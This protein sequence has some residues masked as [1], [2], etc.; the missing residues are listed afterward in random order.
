MGGGWFIRLRR[1]NFYRLG[2]LGD[3][4]AQ[5]LPSIDQIL[6]SA[7]EPKLFNLSFEI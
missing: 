5:L 7:E 1:E 4:T 6:P 2:R 3:E